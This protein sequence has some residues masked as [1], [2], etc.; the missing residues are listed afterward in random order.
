VAHFSIPE[1]GALS[2]PVDTAT[3]ASVVHPARLDHPSPLYSLAGGRLGL[4]RPKPGRWGT[5]RLTTVGRRT[6]RTRAVIL[7]YFE[8]GPNVVTMARNGWGDAE[9]ASWLNL[10]V[11][12]DVTVELVD[13]PRQVTGRPAEGDSESG[14]G[15]DGEK[16]TRTSMP[17]Q[18]AGRC[19]P[20]LSSSSH[21]SALGEPPPLRPRRPLLVAPRS[22]HIATA[23]MMTAAAR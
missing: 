20:R 16:S 17:T 14:Y 5:M 6:G 4:R 21:G 15:L 8:N 18:R 22:S 10:Q 12:P 13:G 11:D 3:S 1:S 9:P 2:V 7:G 23:S 19:Q